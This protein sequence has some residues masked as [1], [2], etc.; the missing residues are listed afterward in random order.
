MY[1]PTLEQ[2]PSS[3]MSLRRIAQA[4]GHAVPCHKALLRV[5]IAGAVAGGNGPPL[6]NRL[7]IAMT[8]PAP[9]ARTTTSFEEQHVTGARDGR[10]GAEPMTSL[11]VRVQGEYLE[12]PGLRLTVRQAARL[13]G[14]SIDFAAAVLDELRRA[15]ILACSE[16]GTYSLATEPSRSTARGF[17]DGVGGGRGRM[18]GS[19]KEASVER[20]TCL[21]RHWTWASE[22]LTRF[23]R[24]LADGW[25]YGE[26]L[27]GLRR[28]HEAFGEALRSEQVSRE[29]D[30]VDVEAG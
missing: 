23:E 15:S 22:A 5:V 12:M 6:L 25:D 3:W 18:S 28:V 2:S 29:V 20:L 11:A 17:A 13:F 9:V 26:T 4:R 27:A 16:T 7:L 19:L 24:E 1:R 21:R 14:I 8:T 10:R 30:P